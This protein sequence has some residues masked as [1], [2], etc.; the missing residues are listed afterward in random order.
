M[1][2]TEW[3]AAQAGGGGGE[4][5]ADRATAAGAGAGPVEK[6]VCGHEGVDSGRDHADDANASSALGSLALNARPTASQGCAPEGTRSK[7]NNK[8]K[9]DT[10]IEL[11]KGTFLK[12]LDT[13]LH[14]PLTLPTGGVTVS[15]L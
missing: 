1:A 2:R 3:C 12:R 10:S 11:R 5:V 6:A 14:C 8:R 15:C 13:L 7:G 4:D 9:G